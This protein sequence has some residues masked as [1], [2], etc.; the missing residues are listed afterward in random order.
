MNRTMLF[1]L[2]LLWFLHPLN[3]KDDCHLDCARSF[4]TTRSASFRQAIHQ[5]LWHNVF[6]SG[7]GDFMGNGNITLFY[8]KSIP[9]DQTQRYFLINGKK[10]ILISGDSNTHDTYTRDVRAE[11]LGLPNDFRGTM[12]LSPS[13]RQIGCWLEC[14]QQLRRYIDWSFFENSWINIR[15]PFVFVDNN[16]NP[17]YY[18]QINSSALSLEKAFN[19]PTWCFSKIVKHTSNF[20]LAEIRISLGKTF[21]DESYF[22]LSYETTLTIPTAQKQNPRYMF[23]AVVGVNGHAAFGNKLTFQILLNRD[24]IHAAWTFYTNLEAFLLIANRQKRTFDLRSKANP[25]IELYQKQWSRFLIYT[26]QDGTVIDGVNALTRETIVNPY[27]LVD[28]SAG[29]RLKIKKFEAEIGY[30]F[31]GHGEEKLS[32]PKTLYADNVS[33]PVPL[34]ILGSAPGITAS[35]SSIDTKSPD[36]TSFIAINDSDFDHHSAAAATALTHAIHASVGGI[37]QGRKIDS[38]AGF[39]GF[40]EISQKNSALTTYGIWGKIG[41]SF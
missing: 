2:W 4:M 10:E 1:L 20:G 8:Q 39:G 27:T 11:W 32:F 6:Y 5:H 12:S 25:A 30:N 18:T 21:I 38:F 26:K 29:W 24:P 40:F 15:L 16:L 13:Q 14:N 31:W 37:Y 3:A 9:Q 19:N 35:N 41:A 22:Q 28:F 34:G 17:E 36:D 23:D 33:H 7:K